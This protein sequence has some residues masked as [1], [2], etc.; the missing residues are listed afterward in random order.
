MFFIVLIVSS[1]R[2]FC[3]VWYF[4]VNYNLVPNHKSG[5]S[6]DNLTRSFTIWLI[7]INILSWL[8]FCIVL[9]SRQSLDLHMSNEKITLQESF[10]TQFYHHILTVS[11]YRKVKIINYKLS[12]H[13]LRDG[14]L[15][16]GM[17]YVPEFYEGQG[18]Q[19]H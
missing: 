7:Y 1:P 11:V 6:L 14:W 18:R 2:S 12:F 4:Q 8:F 15:G 10:F 13:I 3:H 19:Q 5:C 16:L 17:E 9:F